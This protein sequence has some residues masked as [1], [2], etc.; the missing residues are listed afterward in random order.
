LVGRRQRCL[1]Q[2]LSV[3]APEDMEQ[4]AQMVR[5]TWKHSWEPVE[6]LKD[7]PELLRMLTKLSAERR[8]RNAL[9]PLRLYGARR[10]A[11][12]TPLAQQGCHPDAGQG[13]RAYDSA[14]RLASIEYNPINPDR[15]S[16]PPGQYANCVCDSA[17]AHVP[18]RSMRWASSACPSVPSKDSL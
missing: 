11:H 5:V 12:L 9:P 10:D 18:V 2:W 8:V 3:T 14:L 6:T 1:R 4:R 7:D 17:P 15:D 13:T 16:A